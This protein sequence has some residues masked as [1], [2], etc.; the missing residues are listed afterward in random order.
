M[1]LFIIWCIDQVTPIPPPPRPSS[2]LTA[3]LNTLLLPIGLDMSTLPELSL[4]RDGERLVVR[5]RGEGAASDDDNDN[6]GDQAVSAKGIASDRVG[7][8]SDGGAL[9]RAAPS[10]AFPTLG[11]FSSN[12]GPPRPTG[13]SE[14]AA[15][16]SS[17]SV[18]LIPQSH[19]TLLRRREGYPGQRDAEC[20][21]VQRGTVS[22]LALMG[23]RQLR[24]IVAIF[25]NNETSAF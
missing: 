13:T 7:G 14:A 2:P 20:G 1:E 21:A 12:R 24:Y 9:H 17:S 15:V 25:V 11:L 18:P 16:T 23:P 8:G 5:N 6:S 10:T 3:V 22:R 19:F 4:S